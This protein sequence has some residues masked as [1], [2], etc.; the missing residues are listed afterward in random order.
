M[1]FKPT[2]GRQYYAKEYGV[3]D[4]SGQVAMAR[5][6]QEV[7]KEATQATLKFARSVADDNYN[8]AV[9]QAEADGKTN[10]VIR[11]PDTNEIKPLVDLDYTK[12]DDNFMTN[13]QRD[14]VKQT[15]R[16]AAF[17]TYASAVGN[18][19][20]NDAEAVFLNNKTDPDAIRGA[21]NGKL[22]SFQETLDPSL[23]ALIEPKIVSA[24]RKAENKAFA[25]QQIATNER[26]NADNSQALMNNVDQIGILSSKLTGDNVK[27]R[28]ILDTISELREE[29]EAIYEALELHEYGAANIQKLKMQEA[30][31]VA[32]KMATATAEKIYYSPNG[33]LIKAIEA[34]H[35]AEKQ[36]E[37]SPDIDG[38]KVRDLMLSEI[39]KLK[40]ID[41]SKVSE[42]VKSD[43]KI[44]DEMKLRIR[45]DV[46]SVTRDEIIKLPLSDDGLKAALIN[47]YDAE[48][49]AQQE[50]AK[51]KDEIIDKANA[52][53][54]DRN[55]NIYLDNTTSDQEKQSAALLM[56][57]SYQAG[58]VDG[59]KYKLFVNARNK[60]INADI[61]A[62]GTAKM[63]GID[64]MMAKSSGYQMKPDYFLGL[65][66]QLIQ[67]KIIGEGRAITLSSW[68]S[69]V[70][71]YRNA[72]K[73]Y[74]DKQSEIRTALSN[75]KN[76]VIPSEGQKNLI[77]EEYSPQF[78][79]DSKGSVF[80]HEDLNVREDNFD[81]AM[82]FALSYK[83]LHP[84]MVSA[85]RS[86]SNASITDE[87][88]EVAVQL[89]NKMHDTLAHGVNK[90][91]TSGLGVGDIV[92]DTIIS[93]SGVDTVQY[94]MARFVGYKDWQAMQSAGTGTTSGTRVVNS[95]ES[96]FGS[97]LNEVIS[98]NLGSAIQP[99]TL[100]ETI[101]NNTF[102]D[103]DRDPK[104]LVKLDQL[105]E[106]T[107]DGRSVDANDLF[108]RDPRLNEYIRQSVVS[109]M[110]L[111]KLPMTEKG[112]QVAIRKTVTDV[113]TKIGINFDENDQPYIGFNTWY[114]EASSSIGPNVDTLPEGGVSA[115][116][117]RDIKRNVLRP[118]VIV[119]ERVKD[120]IE[121]GN[122]TLKIYP[123]QQ[124]G[125]EQTYSAY[126]VTPE[127]ESIQ[128]LRNYR[129]D[130]KRSIDYPVMQAAVNRVKN[131][132][133][134]KFFSHINVLRG[135]IVSGVSEKILADF[136]G[137]ADLIGLGQP[138]LFIGA[139][140]T[141]NETLNAVKPVAGYLTNDSYT[142][143]PQVDAED[144]KILRAWLNGDFESEEAFNMALQESLSE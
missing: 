68:R 137:D 84:D 88:F 143:D 87:S 108:I 91:G 61:K 4:V 100:I 15:W 133:L 102:W 78:K 58:L 70:E 66:D 140:E 19:A 47:I 144:V 23:Y 135:P 29:N 112:I 114:K 63:A 125:R 98:A 43:K 142:I 106:S 52:E 109:N 42:S 64:M 62:L 13:D 89:Y 25:N 107:P 60:K 57:A 134:K 50:S 37:N 129:Y 31:I 110:V 123:D 34:A 56:E 120:L 32:N 126:V 14:A 3:V 95:I 28:A 48:S 40:F 92:A 111:N 96:T 79:K 131:S 44:S 16:N 53:G 55:L 33:G 117:F 7:G 86:L 36:F 54:F 101:I 38:A 82:R 24:Y 121:S 73:T 139:L 59:G 8:Q 141:L 74:H 75:A 72:Y 17:Q 103:S 27:D 105:F 90:A 130:Y 76:G 81:M 12:A 93:N 113:G 99:S 11:D 136:Q 49:N 118:D 119:D 128:V 2:Q 9:R 85:M 104:A 138:E 35:A 26:A 65:E 77:V 5:A 124:F 1:V 30:T 69:K 132:T 115:A 10:A 97:N 39:S 22:E 41:D 122:G 94:N 18:D 45:S 21:L 6:I 116:V 80:F 67:E 46:S 71:T 83:F 20:I 51:Q 127:R